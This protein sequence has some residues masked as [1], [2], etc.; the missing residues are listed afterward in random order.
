MESD[1]LIDKTGDV[2]CQSGDFVI[3]ESLP[4]EVDAIIVASPGHYK[5]TPML[6]PS[7]LRHMRGRRDKLAIKREVS[8]AMNMDNKKLQSLT[9]SGNQ[10][11]VQVK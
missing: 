5:Q 3:G 6:G 8:I 9:I 4:Q 2:A 7:L 11:N 10:L 1:I